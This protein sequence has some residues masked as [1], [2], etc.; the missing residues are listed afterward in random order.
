MELAILAAAPCLFL[1]FF[2]EPPIAIA[3]SVACGVR[4]CRIFFRQC[5]ARPIKRVELWT[6]GGA[7]TVFAS[8]FCGCSERLAWAEYYVAALLSARFVISALVYREGDST[9]EAMKRL[10]DDLRTA[11]GRMRSTG[12]RADGLERLR[13][14]DR[15]YNDRMQA[16]F[17]RL[18]ECGA[19]LKEKLRAAELQR[20][21]TQQMLFDLQEELERAAAHS[22]DARLDRI[23]DREVRRRLDE[24]LAVVEC[25]LDIMS[26][27]ISFKVMR[28]LKPRLRELLERGVEIKILYGSGD[29]TDAITRKAAKALRKEF[30]RYSNFR[31]SQ[32][33]GRG[34]VFICDE[35]FYVRS[36]FNVLSYNGLMEGLNDGEYSTDAESLRA[37][38]EQYFGF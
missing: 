8:T 3:L 33:D 11:L 35:K 24:A 36:G 23:G 21:D 2:P 18:D 16:L 6:V 22:I 13:A 15:A 32:G 37:I 4:L 25:E 38:R 17:D 34:K 29:S 1:M 7:A 12:L 31:M 14:L 19:Q 9:F 20:E 26:A 30:K 10:N 27:R 5:R 28:S